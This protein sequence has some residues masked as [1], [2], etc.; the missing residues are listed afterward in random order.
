MKKVLFVCMENA[1]R[2][3]MVKGFFNSYTNN[4]MVESDGLYST[5]QV[6]PRAVQVLKEKNS[7]SSG[8]V[9]QM[10][11]F[12]MK[13]EFD[14]L[15]TM[16]C[17]DG[18]PLPPKNKMDAGNIEDPKGGTLKKYRE[19]RDHIENHVHSLIEEVI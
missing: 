2:S 7:D 8:F 9:P 10:L 11:S 13:N 6:D 5:E 4:A 19:I 12:S 18:F 14:G 16:D 1:C 3:Q 15:I 17:T